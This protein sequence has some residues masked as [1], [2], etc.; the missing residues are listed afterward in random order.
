MNLPKMIH[1]NDSYTVF[2]GDFRDEEC[3]EYQGSTYWA[4]YWLV[5]KAS[6]VQEYRT[7][8]LPDALDN[9]ARMDMALK[10]KPWEA[11]VEQYSDPAEDFP[12]E[13]TVH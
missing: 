8:S 7:I 6:E 13:G 11:Y 1:E 10:Q 9:A 4:G 12:S 5:N 3:I 2:G